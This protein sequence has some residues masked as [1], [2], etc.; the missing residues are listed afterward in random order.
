MELVGQIRENK[1]T[2]FNDFIFERI[3]NQLSMPLDLFYKAFYDDLCANQL[4]RLTEDNFKT[5]D[6]DNAIVDF[7]RF[8]ESFPLEY[9]T[10]K[11]DERFNKTLHRRS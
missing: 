4:T 11:I 10:K 3:S 9:V 5:K 8:K 7:V 2:V 1:T 6:G